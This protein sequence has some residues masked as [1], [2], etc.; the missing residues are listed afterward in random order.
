[1]HLKFKRNP[2]LSY[3]SDYLELRNDNLN[4]PIQIDTCAGNK[5]IIV[6]NKN[7]VTQRWRLLLECD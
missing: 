5:M 2:N 7:F 6:S 3:Y 1:M 4:V